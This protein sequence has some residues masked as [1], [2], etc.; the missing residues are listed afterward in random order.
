L[1]VTVWLCDENA[2][3]G[4][5]VHVYVYTSGSV[6]VAEPVR[7]A[8]VPVI[9]VDGLTVIVTVGAAGG[10]TVTAA[11]PCRACGRTEVSVAVTVS[12]PVVVS[13]V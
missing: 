13:A 12:G 7:V 3:A 11:V 2:A 4:D 8:V 6:P 10:T 9:V 5:A 1:L